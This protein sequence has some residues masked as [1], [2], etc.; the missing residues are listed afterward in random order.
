MFP[1]VTGRTRHLRTQSSNSMLV[2]MSTP[3][4]RAL[5][6]RYYTPTL[7]SLSPEAHALLVERGIPPSEVI[8]HVHSIRDKAWEVYPYP[9]VGRFYFVRTLIAKQSSYPAILS[10][11]VSS[12]PDQTLLDV[13]CGLGQELRALISAGVKP[14]QVFGLDLVDGF[15]KLGYQ[16]FNDEEQLPNGQ[17]I[18][19][20]LLVPIPQ[21]LD[22]AFDVI[23]ASAFFHLFDWD[24][25]VTV[26][27]HTVA[28]LKPN[29]GSFLFG[30][31]LGYSKGKSKDNM[32]VPGGTCYLHDPESFQKL[33]T[34]VGKD[35][36]TQWHVS[37]E[38][39]TEGPEYAKKG[40][41]DYR[42]LR[43]RVERL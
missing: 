14:E 18:I 8:K 42:I 1:N 35:T 40:D 21:E 12:P 17:F 19:H 4:E 36:E 28:L 24:D 13:G 6:G 30:H 15:I 25:Q 38:N 23:F 3:A 43:F 11:L 39:D 22:G 29:K 31:Q 33:W 20:N 27:K 37:V 41:P 7:E 26:T 9:C 2:T 5:D 34:L 10:R 16:L 32:P